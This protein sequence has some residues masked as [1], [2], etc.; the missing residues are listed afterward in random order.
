MKLCDVPFFY[1]G[2]IVQHKNVKEVYNRI[3]TVADTLGKS[4][5]GEVSTRAPRVTIWSNPASVLW[6][7]LPFEEVW[8]SVSVILH[9]IVSH[10]YQSCS[11]ISYYLFFCE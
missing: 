10:I 4:N 11:Y 7:K 2:V 6:Y 5:D 3:I 8:R 9:L 1:L